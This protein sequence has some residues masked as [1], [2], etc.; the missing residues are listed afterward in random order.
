MPSRWTN[1]KDKTYLGGNF[2]FNI[3]GNLIYFSLSPQLGYKITENFS[4]GITAKYV[5]L[6]PLQKDSPLLSYKYYGG[7]AFARYRISYSLVATVEYERLNVEDINLN[8]FQYKERV[9]SDV[10]LLGGGYNSKLSEN[11][12]LQL[13]LL[14]DV[15]D[16]PNSPYR[17]NYIFGPNSIPVIYRIGF[18][19]G[20]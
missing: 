1:I 9:W 4:T 8:S 17:Y 3:S 10:L 13:Y 19:F 5:Y 2:G 7:G 20:L 18:I 16:D 11:A 15:I 6:G 14:Y 12:F